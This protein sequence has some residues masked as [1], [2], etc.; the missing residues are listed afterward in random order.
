MNIDFKI[1]RNIWL[2]FI[3]FRME[4]LRGEQMMNSHQKKDKKLFVS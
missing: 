1:S 3:R 4:S 2:N